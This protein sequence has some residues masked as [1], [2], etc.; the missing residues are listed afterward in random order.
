MVLLRGIPAEGK[1]KLHCSSQEA[2]CGQKS[3]RPWSI[4][5]GKGKAPGPPLCFKKSVHTG[6]GKIQMHLIISSVTLRHSV[7]CLN[8]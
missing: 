5:I 3:H 2:G 7:K 6:A 8:L 4:I 1:D